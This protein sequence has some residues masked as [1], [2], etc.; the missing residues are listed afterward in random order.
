[1][2]SVPDCGE[3]QLCLG[4]TAWAVPTCPV[5][6]P[7]AQPS[8]RRRRFWHRRESDTHHG[9]WS[10]AWGP[11]VGIPRASAVSAGALRERWLENRPVG[12][13]RTCTTAV[14]RR[15]GIF[16]AQ[17]GIACPHEVLPVVGLAPG[18]PGP[19]P[20]RAGAV[21]ST[22]NLAHRKC[23]QNDKKKQRATGA[24]FR[25]A[26]GACFQKHFCDAKTSPSSSPTSEL[27][28]IVFAELLGLVF[29]SIFAM[30]K[31]PPVTF[32]KNSAPA[33]SDVMGS[34]FWTAPGASGR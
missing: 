32:R 10:G 3:H 28:G 15:G 5:T 20:P 14:G 1:M 19:N 21:R 17:G 24:C 12:R 23:L 29:R 34:Y 6:M 13:R 22:I 11:L 18:S 8:W 7:R 9:H 16:G 4:V 2:F 25:R 30:K 27:L 31:Q 33:L 26:T